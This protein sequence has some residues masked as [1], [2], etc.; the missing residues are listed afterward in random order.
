MHL[1][2]QIFRLAQVLLGLLR[3]AAR[4]LGHSCT[5][6]LA[7]E[8]DAHSVRHVWLRAHCIMC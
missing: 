6:P 7:P 5:S 1:S 3:E 8:T 2:V 4:H